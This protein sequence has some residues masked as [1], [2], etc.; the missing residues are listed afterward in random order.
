MNTGHNKKIIRHNKIRFIPKFYA[1]DIMNCVSLI[2]LVTSKHSHNSNIIDKN[3]GVCL[4][5]NF[6]FQRIFVSKIREKYLFVLFFKKVW[7]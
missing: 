4:Y 6:K 5:P 7:V 2:N 1:L 3:N